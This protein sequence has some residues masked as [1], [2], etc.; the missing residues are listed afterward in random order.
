MAVGQSAAGLRYVSPVQ[1]N[2][3]FTKW[4]PDLFAC[5]I[6]VLLVATISSY[7]RGHTCTGCWDGLGPYSISLSPLTL[8]LLAHSR[9]CRMHQVPL[10]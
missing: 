2:V 9:Q 4:K 1:P 7:T 5:V 3:V 10:E 6:A 8:S